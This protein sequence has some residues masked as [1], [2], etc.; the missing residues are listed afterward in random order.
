MLRVKEE[1]YANKLTLVH[2][3][4][5]IVRT[6]PELANLVLQSSQHVWTNSKPTTQAQQFIKNARTTI[7]LATPT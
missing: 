1:Q 5:Q 6:T 7:E 3:S 4:S 2:Q